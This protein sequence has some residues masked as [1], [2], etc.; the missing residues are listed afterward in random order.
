VA[1]NFG[2]RIDAFL[3]E[4]GDGPLEIKNHVDQVYAQNQELTEHFEHPRGGQAHYLRDALFD[5]AERFMGHIAQ[6][7]ITP[8]GSR[9]H[10]AAEHVANELV[11]ETSLRT[12]VEFGDLKRSGHATV[13]SDGA[14]VYDKPPEVP[15]LTEEQ[16]KR[17]HLPEERRKMG[18]GF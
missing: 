9:I 1:G 18:L 4:F 7:V 11:R 15:R 14:V 10:H 8:E 12:P 16:L 6:E 17:K 5:N 2:E 13:T 3:E